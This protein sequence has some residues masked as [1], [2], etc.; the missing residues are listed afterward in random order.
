MNPYELT[1]GTGPV[2]VA[3]PHVGTEL[4][5]GLAERL[6]PEARRVPDTDWHV[7]ALYRAAPSLGCSILRA[8]YSRYVVDLNRPADDTPMYPGQA[9][10]GVI[11][12]ESFDGAA[13]YLS[14]SPPSADETAD[15]IAR[16]WRPY[17]EALAA[18][19]LRIKA[20]WGWAVLW[21]AHSIRSTVPRLFDGR[22][23]DLNFGS[24]DG[25]SCQAE[26]AE[27]LL[28]LAQADGHYSAVLNGRFKGGYTTRHY[29]QPA[30]RIH[31]LQLEISQICYLADEEITFALSEEKTT[32]LGSL[33]AR[34]VE[35]AAEWR[36]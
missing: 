17:H 7:D 25:R 3:M 20:Q 2:L 28:A 16:Y 32:A 9:N 34:L 36:P 11:P 27:G 18:E 13:L 4:S 15:R 19:L 23:P 1:I 21:D 30:D 26:L 22:L 29:G 10:T 5:P 24:Y 35:L 6:M 12:T 8:N 14:G 33:I 31:A